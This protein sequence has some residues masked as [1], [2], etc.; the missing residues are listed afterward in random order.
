MALPQVVPE[1][2]Q[3][4]CRSDVA[5][6]PEC[7]DKLAVNQD[8]GRFTFALCLR[9][10]VLDNRE[11]PLRAHVTIYENVCQHFGVWY[12]NGFPCSIER[13]NVN[14]LRDEAA[15]DGLPVRRC[16]EEKNRIAG[17]DPGLQESRDGCRERVVALVELNGMKEH[18][19]CRSHLP[20]FDHKRLAA[21]H[22]TQPLASA[23]RYIG[24]RLPRT[25]SFPA[26]AG[27]A[28]SPSP[29]DAPTSPGFGAHPT[30]V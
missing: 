4:E 8:M 24:N 18:R 3:S 25:V 16:R 1:R 2:L 21:H 26:Y 28:S 23:E 22:L 7:I 17:K 15:V 19:G 11:E 29:G 10:D 9:D 6:P 27:Q 12:G 20:D 14:T 30:Q 13:A 5:L